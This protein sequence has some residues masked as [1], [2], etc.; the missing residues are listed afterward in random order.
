M[1]KTL[2]YKLTAFLAITTIIVVSCT[3]ESPD[4]RLDP[5]LSTSQVYGIKSDSATVVG[6][7]IA[8]GEGFV[9]KGICYNTQPIPTILNSKK[10]Y[11]GSNTTATFIVKLGGLTFATKYY[12]RA[13][14]TNS[15]GTIYGEESNFTTLAILPT[16]TTADVTAIAGTTATTGGNVTH[17]G[18]ATITARGVCYSETPNPTIANLKTSDGTGVGAFVSSLANLKGATTYYVRAYATNVIGTAYGSQKQFTTLVV[19][20]TWYLPGDYVEA[21]YPGTTFGNWSPAN[22]PQVKSVEAAPNILEGYVYMANTANE[23]KFATQPNWDGPNYGYGGPGILDP[24]GANFNS[25]AGYYK[26]NANAVALTYTA[27]ATVWG[28]IGSASP[29]GWGSE[30]PLSYDPASRT[31]RGGVPMTLGDF[32]FRAHSWDYNYGA[33]A[34][35]NKLTHDG[36]NIAIGVA[37]DYYFVLDLSTPHDYT[38]SADRWGL[39]GSATPGGWGEDTNMMWDPVT[40]SLK[41]TVDLTV[42]DIKFRAND[43]WDIN[44]GGTPSALT[45]GGDNIPIA[46]AGNYTIHLYLVGVGGYCTIVKN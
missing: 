42:G 16:A 29:G 43:A 31:W 30:T 12:A 4:V 2:I 24:S 23:W 41:L 17:N 35:S 34:G 45:P 14:A 38:Y 46:L 32:K 18:G 27:V 11:T 37:A 15:S 13:Y 9:E 20:R 1:K 8:S 6:F 25:P 28:V 19:T 39:I 10:V 40:K 36:P 5:K 33:A 22:S 3:K 21:S 7:V 44:L 26:I